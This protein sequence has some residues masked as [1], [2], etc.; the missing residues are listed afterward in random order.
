MEPPS[1]ITST[2]KSDRDHKPNVDCECYLKKNTKTNE[3]EK[4]NT[5][6]FFLRQ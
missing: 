5:E 2:S 6:S 1:A 4:K 3:I